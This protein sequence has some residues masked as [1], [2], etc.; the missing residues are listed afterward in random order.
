MWSGIFEWKKSDCSYGSSIQMSSN[1]LMLSFQTLH[2]VFVRVC[3][4]APQQIKR[5]ADQIQNAGIID[6][7]NRK[8]K[9]CSHAP[10][11]CMGKGT[12]H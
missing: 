9:G 6:V 7:M 8:N 1:D 2:G 11:I 4:R 10:L 3:V 12:D 5:R